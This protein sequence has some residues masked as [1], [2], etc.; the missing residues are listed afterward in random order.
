MDFI[1][2]LPRTSSGHN[3]IWVIVDR[4]TKST[5]LLSIQEDYPTEKLARLYIN[6]IV[7]RHGVPISIISIRDG[8]FTSRFWQIYH[9]SV[10][11]APFEALYGR[12]CRSPVFWA[13]VGE[14]QMIEPQIVQET[15]DKIFKIKDRLK[16]ARDRQKSYADNISK[17]LG[18][19]LAYRLK[20]PQELNGVHDMFHV[21]NLKKCL[22][23]KTL[24]VLFEEIQIDAKLHFVEEPVE[25]MDR[26]VKKLKRS[27]ISIVKV[28]WNSKRGPEFTWG[29]ED[30]MKLKYPYL[31]KDE[32]VSK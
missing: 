17:T 27:R 11:C 21:S 8:R 10:K 5:H 20:L 28:R 24:H 12:K 3:S 2:K 9:T 15:T 4:L 18:I 1:T 14:S 6:E 26:E 13:K 19:L 29:Q 16:T 31:F 25:I 22:A 30:Y 23:N 32:P 7:A